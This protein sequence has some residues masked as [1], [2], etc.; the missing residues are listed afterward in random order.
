MR[1]LHL[2]DFHFKS[3]DK[4]IAAQ[5]ILIDKLLEDLGT[6]PK[7]DFLLFTGD[8][9]FSGS[10]YDDFQK[11]YETFFKRIGEKLELPKR[12]AIFCPGNHDVDRDKVSAP[13][14]DFIRQFKNSHSLTKIV[15]DNKEDEF[16]LTCKPTGNYYQFAKWFYSKSISD[17]G[18]EVNQLYSIHVRE[19]DKWKIGFVSINT[20]WCSTGDDDKGNLFFPKSELEKAINKLSQ[21]NVQWKVLLLHHPLADFR[22]FNKN[23]LEDIIYSEFHLMFSGH[24]HKRDDFIRLMQNEGIFG[25]FAHAA[26]TKKEDGKIGYSILNI[27]LDTLEIKMQ[28]NVYDFEEFVFL[29]LKEMIF[30]FPCNEV[31]HDQIK[32]FKTLK[33][34]LSEVI[35]KANELCVTK[36]NILQKGFLDLFVEPVLKRQPQVE[37][38]TSLNQPPK[39]DFKGL[40]SQKNLFIYGKDKTG[41]TS[42]LFKLAIDLLNSFSQLGEIPFYVDLAEFKANAAK[43]DLQKSLSKYLEHTFRQTERILDTYKFKILIDNFDP[44]KKDI[45]DKLSNF[46]KR[47]INCTYIIVADQ[48][49]AQ[50][51]E[52]I[53]YG[54]NG[55][56]KIFIH[57]ISRN[58]IRQLTKKWPSIPVEK[59]D[60]FV[61]RIV[62]VLKQHSMPFNFWTISI[63][64]WI[65]SGKNTLNFNNNS[66]L[67]ELYID[68]VLDRNRLA[69]DSQNRFSFSNYKLLLGELAHHL[70]TNHR[71]TN[72]SIIFSDLTA[73]VE[74]F[75]RKNIR[76][77]GN[78]SEIVDHLL[79]RGV[80]KKLE[81]DFVT[82]RLNGVFEYFIAFNFIE[83]KDFFEVI[84]NDDNYYL[85]FKNEFEIYSG[86]QRNEAE[87]RELLNKFFEKTKIAFKEL[88]ERM[89]GDL[90]FRLTKA[91]EGKELIDLSKPIAL[92]S[93]KSN[94][95]PLS[96]EEKDEFLDE[97]NAGIIRD[98][99]VKPKKIYDVSIK[100]FDILERYLL[101]NGRVFK[102]I[103]NI[104]DSEFVNS[105]FDFI[106]DSSCNLGFLLIEEFESDLDEKKIE[107]LDYT[108]AKKI[109]FQLISN[110]LPSV[111]QSFIHEAT[112]HVNLEAIINNRIDLLKRDYQN[113]QFK[114]FILNCLLLDIDFKRYKNKID[115]LI[116][117]SRMGIIKSSVLIKICYLLLFKS[118]DDDEMIAFLREKMRDINVSIN[119]KTDMKEF[120]RNFEKAKKLLL[121]K[122]VSKD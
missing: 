85:A 28:K 84:L 92:L 117:Y 37:A 2:S 107:E 74:S 79:N 1:I 91:I 56:E 64:L 42:L 14:K 52:K 16:G 109:I 67:L 19:L 76:R 70:L 78:T 96:D 53:D 94:L 89:E 120:D 101:I 21:A 7:I 39:I 27:D 55:Y 81:D 93:E 99:E 18:D 26:F 36:D 20:A 32:I 119:P 104:N 33:K 62:D 112:G 59:R 87:N 90:D 11:A 15:E 3:L 46:F 49:L 23:E 34:R 114:L 68:D 77:V 9:V 25:T 103:D 75:K 45:V 6:K 102:N 5:N 29:P 8:I 47:Y 13:I 58:E 111:V 10:K 66:E 50:T 97:V 71:E 48:T 63:F 24:L 17:L 54:L 12:N 95:A 61:E 108:S 65:F 106:I 122:R 100:K 60:E 113:N 51:Y 110:Y 41:K 83:N 98:V 35:E 69:S 88:N 4:D 121:L 86:F 57:D 30:T 82:F 73:F 44:T 72:Y 118:Y 80:L 31:K 22:D 40:Y 115:D 43:F 105:I 38:A 116:K